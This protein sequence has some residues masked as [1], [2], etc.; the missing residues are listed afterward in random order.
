MGKSGR[1][2]RRRILLQRKGMDLIQRL[3]SSN[4]LDKEDG[5]VRSFRKRKSFDWDKR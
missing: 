5:H 2:G 3:H 1:G 4:K